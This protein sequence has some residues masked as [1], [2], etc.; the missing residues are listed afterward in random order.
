MWLGDVCIQWNL[1]IKVTLDEGHL[2]N[3]GTVCSPNYV[4]L[5]T[6]LRTSELR[7]PLCTGQSA[8]SQWCP[9]QRGTTVFVCRCPFEV[10]AH[11]SS[12]KSHQSKA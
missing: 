3:E 4:E 6:K 9:Q 12:T 5:C 1:S 7:K 8:G 10:C 11:T 2:S